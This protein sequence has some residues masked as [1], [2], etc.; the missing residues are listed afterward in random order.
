MI[1]TVTT[2]IDAPPLRPQVKHGAAT[3]TAESTLMFGVMVVD[4]TSSAGASTLAAAMRRRPRT[5]NG[6]GQRIGSVERA[7]CERA[8]LFDRETVVDIGVLHAWH[9]SSR[10]LALNDGGQVVG[11]S[12]HGA[13]EHAFV[14]QHG[15]MHDLCGPIES[16]D[17]AAL[18]PVQAS[19]AWDI[20]RRGLVVGRAATHDRV[21]GFLW[22]LRYGLVD[23]GDLL[24]RVVAALSWRIV[25][26]RHVDDDDRILAT[27]ECEGRWCDVLLLP[28]R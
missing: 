13:R 8:A 14:W 12:R 15:R 19:R 1:G 2:R 9:H 6:L 27:A 7:G 17:A 5:C 20:N 23:L 4:V 24:P 25:E 11:V 22:S 28:R 3:T 18:R 26:A 16:C 21:F 10:A